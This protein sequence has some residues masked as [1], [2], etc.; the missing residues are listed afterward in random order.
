MKR[1]KQ[2]WIAVLTALITLLVLSFQTASA[3]IKNG[4]RE[5][6]THVQEA[7]NNLYEFLHNEN[8][9]KSEKQAVKASIKVL[10]DHILYYELTEQL[11]AQFRLIAPDLYKEVDIIVDIQGRPVDVYIKFVPY[12]GTD[13]EAFGTTYICQAEDDKDMYLSKYGERTVS[14]KIWIVPKAFAVLA[15]ELGH[16]KYQVPNLASYVDYYMEH[17]GNDLIKESNNLG[18]DP[19][20]PSGKSASEFER[21]FRGQYSS[22]RKITKGKGERPLYLFNKIKNELRADSQSSLHK[23]KPVSS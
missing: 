2:L 10:E 23:P 8:L 11:L 15:H 12:Y 6:I 21:R 22:Y 4:Y 3:E 9:T 14:V 1:W 19:N 5:E 17:Y 16:V 18:H 7:L 20:D 13:V